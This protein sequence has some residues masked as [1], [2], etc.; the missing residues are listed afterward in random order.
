MSIPGF[1]TPESTHHFVNQFQSHYAAH[2]YNRLGRTGLAVSRI[3]FGTYRC[4]QGIEAHR[5]ALKLALRRGCNL[6]DTSANYTDGHAE[7]LIGEVLNEEIVW[8]DLRRENIVIVSKAG[9]IQGENFKIARQR[10]ESGDPF[11]ETVKYQPDLWHNIHPEFIADQVTRSLARLHLDALDIYLLHNPEYFLSDAAHKDIRDVSETRNQFYDRLR[12]AFGQMEKLVKEGL[13][14]CY[15]ISSNSFPLPENS[16]EFVCLA[17]VWQAYEAACREHGLTP[18]NGHFAVIQLPFN[19]IEH[20]A[21]TLKNN[22][23]EGEIYTVL[24]LAKRLDLGVLINRPLNAIYQN[25][26]LRL[27]RIRADK[28]LDALNYQSVKHLEQRFDEAYPQLKSALSFSQKSLLA[29]AGVPGID[30]ILNGMRTPEYVE[31]SLGV[32]R[33]GENISII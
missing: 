26:L 13:I 8:G 9:Y 20:Q 12:R 5:A 32:M 2:A 25:R 15:G 27:A 14:R 17:T 29:A 10:E 30:V 23:F 4:H 18:E 22:V 11:P 19:W 31:D 16:A 28:R 3:G 6:I 1:A 7:A 33:V 21:A 24:E